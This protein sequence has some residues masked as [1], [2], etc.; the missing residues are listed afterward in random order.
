MLQL[1]PT[2]DWVS[3]NRYLE[4]RFLTQHCIHKFCKVRDEDVLE[5]LTKSSSP[6]T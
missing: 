4:D 2:P 5:L 1:Q 3:D 6:V